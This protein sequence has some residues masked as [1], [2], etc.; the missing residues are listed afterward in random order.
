MI[1][2]GHLSIVKQCELLQIHRSGVYYKPRAASEL[3]LELMRLMD[4]HYLQHPFKGANRM[5]TWLTL[6]K[7]YK[8]SKNRIEP[9]YY[10]VM[11]LMAI[12]PGKHTSRRHKAHKVYPYLL[13]NLTV[14]RP[15]QVWADLM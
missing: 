14:N 6:D 1:S 2:K 10:N 12:M 7:G 15:N 9:L 11:G 8:V 5:H 13:R 4:E 3:N